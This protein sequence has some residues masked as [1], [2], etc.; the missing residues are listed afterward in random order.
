MAINS[1]AHIT[2]D[3]NTMYILLSSSHETSDF[4]QSVRGA[5][6]LELSCRVLKPIV[7]SRMTE[8]SKPYP[9]LQPGGCFKQKASV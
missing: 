1:W 4:K 9:K 2:A 8:A 7:D 6:N 5:L 3:P